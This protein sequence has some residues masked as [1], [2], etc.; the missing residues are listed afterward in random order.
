MP[1][2]NQVFIKGNL[3]N[4]PELSYTPN[5][6]PVSKGT[7]AVNE[8]YK[9][10]KKETIERVGFFD[11]VIWNKLAE[12][13][14]E[15]LD[16]GQEVIIAGRLRYEKWEDEQHAKH[17]KIRIIVS[18][19]YFGRKDKGESQDSSPAGDIP[20]VIAPPKNQEEDFE[21]IPGL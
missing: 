2:F 8:K 16:K 11:I 17:S 18:Q 7:I 12:T 20:A 9:N 19:I 21:D 3:T 4:K 10:A 5:G 6:T 13:C 1:I 15:H 14:A